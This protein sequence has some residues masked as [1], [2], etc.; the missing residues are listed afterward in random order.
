MK[1]AKVVLSAALVATT[2]LTGCQNQNVPNNVVKTS[3][4][5]QNINTENTDI[6]ES[7]IAEINK[8]MQ[9]SDLSNDKSFSVSSLEAGKDVDVEI[10]LYNPK[11][12]KRAKFWGLKTA[13]KLLN[14]GSS[15]SK[16][17]FLARKLGG[18][19]PSEAFKTQVLFWVE[20]ADMLRIKGVS[21]DDSFLLVM[22]GITS[23]PH[24]ARFNNPIDQAALKIQLSLLAFQYGKPIPSFDEIKSW[25][26]EATTLAPVLY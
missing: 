19:F 2:F 11:A 24:L 15:P 18:L 7:E 16:R 21:V 12:S 6:S 26:N 8:L 22:S 17:W 3:A 20:R 10:L 23:V 9:N 13:D 5:T 25:T 14:A 4:I 1:A